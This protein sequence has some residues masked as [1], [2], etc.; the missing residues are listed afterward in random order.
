[1]KK[2]LGQE[3]APKNDFAMRRSKSG[4]IMMRV[5]NVEG[6]SWVLVLTIRSRSDR[7]S[8][9]GHGIR[10][11]GRNIEHNCHVIN[12]GIQENT[13]LSAPTKGTNTEEQGIKKRRILIPIMS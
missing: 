9:S 4:K 8:S 5:E 11:A 10:K 1:M 7:L 12:S 13:G 2:V 6:Q 3:E